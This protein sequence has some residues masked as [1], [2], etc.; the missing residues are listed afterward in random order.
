MSTQP[1]IQTV[2]STQVRSKIGVI[3][4]QIALLVACYAAWIITQHL[5]EIMRGHSATLTDHTHILLAP[6]NAWLNAHSLIANVIL[7]I[8]SFEV[9][10]S[11]VMMAFFFFR[12]KQSRPILSL[13]LLLIMRQLC[14]ASISLPPPSGMIWRY[15]GFPTLI[16]TYTTS[17]DFFFSGHMAM[18]TLLAAELRAQ[19]RR[20]RE[21]F[22]AWCVLPVQAFVILA[23]RFHYI[24]DVVAGFLAA[25]VASAVATQL[26]GMLD[27]RMA[28]WNEERS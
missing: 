22:V 12:K 7:A 14:Q 17:T 20:D 11:G 19:G 15:P 9:D 4:P 6:V 1:F 3:A 5:L 26:G 27:D 18:A 2:R 13:F 16:V 8:S 23:M 21:T 28:R 24:T 10:L 25:L